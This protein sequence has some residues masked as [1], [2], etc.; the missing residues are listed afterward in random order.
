MRPEQWIKNTVLF[1]PILFSQN[2]TDL[3]F[4]N[5]VIFA[6]I[7]FCLVSSGVYVLNDVIDLKQD[8]NHPVK[9]FRPLASGQLPLNK[10]I[11]LTI[12]ILI[13]SILLSLLGGVWFSAAIFMYVILNL[14]YSYHLKH[15]VIIDV[16]CIAAG[17]VLRVLAGAVVI[18]VDLSPWLI[19]CTILLALLLGFGKRRHELILLEEDASNH[20]RILSEYSPYFLDQM[21]AVVTSST[22]VIYALYTMSAGVQE[23]LGT[24][25]LNLTIPFVL[26]GIFRY[27]YLV[28]QR[29]E[30]GSPTRM[31]LTDRPLLIDV[32]LWAITAGII[33]YFG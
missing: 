15:I 24:K 4:L 33:L 5:R 30:G 16:M 31:L 20:R 25:H 11:G 23:K 3:S 27:L 21:I 12:F 26:Y 6:F 19:I 8:Q 28:H 10:T 17:F 18:S 29:D 9:K 7:L 2:L 13:G 22:L 32:L 14:C 1:A